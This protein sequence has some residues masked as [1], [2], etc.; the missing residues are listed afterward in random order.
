MQ[1]FLTQI[2][3]MQMTLAKALLAIQHVVDQPTT[4]S[5]LSWLWQQYLSR[6]AH[7]PCPPETRRAKIAFL[8]GGAIE[9]FSTCGRMG[10]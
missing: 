5:I 9:R 10:A 8:A 2:P 7:Q 1:K 3:S 6:V 4:A